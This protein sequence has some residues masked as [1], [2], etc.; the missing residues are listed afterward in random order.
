MSNSNKEWFSWL[1]R[2]VKISILDEAGR[3]QQGLH[4]TRFDLGQDCLRED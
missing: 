3:L 2:V 4:T 1:K